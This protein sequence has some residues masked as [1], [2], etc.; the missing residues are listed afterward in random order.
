MTLEHYAVS[1]SE[2]ISYSVPEYT[3]IDTKLE[4]VKRFLDLYGN[5]TTDF[6]TDHQS[7]EHS[8]AITSDIDGQ[9]AKMT[10]AMMPMEAG[11]EAQ[12]LTGAFFNWA[13]KR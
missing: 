10:V 9:P 5:K 3:S 11:D 12:V 2:A 13:R 7:D 8:F 4:V 1:P 6:S